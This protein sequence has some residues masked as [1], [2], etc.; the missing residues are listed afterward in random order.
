MNDIL[1]YQQLKNNDVALL[2]YIMQLSELALTRYTWLNLPP[3]VDPRALE[4]YLLENGNCLFF[5]DDVMGF[6]AL[7]S[8]NSGSFNVYNIPNKRVAIAPNGYQNELNE[9]NSI[10]IFNNYL[11]SP[12]MPTI[13][14]FANRLWEYDRTIDVNIHAQKTPILMQCDQTQLLSVK[15]LYA[16]YDGNAPVIYT[17]KKF[18]E[19]PIN[20]IRTDAP[21]VADKVGKSREDLWKQAL[22]FIG[23]KVGTN[24]RERMTDDEIRSNAMICDSILKSGLMSRK[25]AV[26]QI[27]EMFNLNI[28]VIATGL[29]SEEE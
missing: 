11:M 24:K 2:R 23:I 10:L 5:E 13:V 20:V 22:E 6:L 15:N 17:N 12:S 29:E 1:T 27:N 9:T 4:L 7:P 8:M 18:E 14:D 26:K 21:F 19:K 3:S 16:K 28:D 25:N